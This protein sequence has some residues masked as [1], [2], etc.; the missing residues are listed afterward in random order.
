M[1]LNVSNLNVDFSSEPSYLNNNTYN[2]NIIQNTTDFI[3]QT[4]QNQQNQQNQQF[5][6]T[7]A[8][9][10]NS[11]LDTHTKS[12]LNDFKYVPDQKHYPA[13]FDMLF[14]TNIIQTSQFEEPKKEE[15]KTKKDHFDFVNDLMKKKN[16]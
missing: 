8:Q 9:T 7:N 11:R 2:S 13:N 12:N 1:P 10:I 16:F 3:S 15:I 6:N 4:Q 5:Y 14:D